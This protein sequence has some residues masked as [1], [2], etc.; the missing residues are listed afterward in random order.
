MGSSI[1]TMPESGQG[2]KVKLASPR[3]R[4]SKNGADTSFIVE[5]V[6]IPETSKPSGMNFIDNMGD[7]GTYKFKG[8][9]AAPFLLAQGL[10]ANLL[11]DPLWTHTHA[12][13]VAAA[14]VEWC[15]TKGA[16]MAT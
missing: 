12:D 1:S 7:Y 4:T 9:V 5:K 15:K 2:F 10:P 8:E 3:G 6:D 11:E 16:T 13:K 14:V